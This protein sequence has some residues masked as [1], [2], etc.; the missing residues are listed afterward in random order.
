MTTLILT[1]RHTVGLHIVAWPCGV[2]ADM[3]GHLC[4]LNTACLI[5]HN[6]DYIIIQSCLGVSQ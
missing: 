1:D 2:I 3:A 6:T 4:L 5:Q